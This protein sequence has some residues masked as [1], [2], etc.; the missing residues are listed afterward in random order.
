MYLFRQDGNLQTVNWDKLIENVVHDDQLSLAMKCAFSQSNYLYHS[1]FQPLVRDVEIYPVIVDK[2]RRLD[3]MNLQMNETVY[4]R[5][6]TSEQETPF[7][8]PHSD[9]KIYSKK[10]FVASDKGLHEA[11]CGRGTRYGVSTRVQRRWDCPTLSISPYGNTLAIAAGEEG[12]FESRLDST[13]WQYSDENLVSHGEVR[14][15]ANQHCNGCDWSYYSIFGKSH[16]NNGFLA[17]FHIAGTSASAST[18]WDETA[19]ER[20]RSFERL[21]PSDELFGRQGFSWASNDKIYQST[22]GRISVLKYQPWKD[23]P[24][25]RVQQI[26]EISIQSWKGDIVSAG[27]AVFGTVI[28]FDNAIVVHLSNGDVK[29]IPGEP[30]RWRVFPRSKNYENQLHVVYEDRLEIWSFNQDYFVD[31]ETKTLGVKP[32]LR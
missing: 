3:D 28:E 15:V 12:L 17:S 30:V 10:M 23:E 24:E 20:I 4:G 14:Q 19:S 13:Y 26:D 7:A 21:I 6:L 22:P 18:P 11:T 8:F 32:F 27:V 1:H 25:N 29:T 5:F 16:L 2:F 9:A 31:Q